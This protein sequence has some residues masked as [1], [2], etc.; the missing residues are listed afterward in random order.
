[1]FSETKP[2]SELTVEELAAALKA[3]HR[4][5][6]REGDEWR[7]LAQHVLGLMKLAREERLSASTEHSIRMR[8]WLGHGHVGQYGDDGEMQCGACLP[9]G[10]YDYKRAS[11]EELL[12]TVDAVSLVAL[13]ASFQEKQP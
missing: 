10:T 6:I 1:M 11:L 9:F 3:G 4:A 7:P 8:L 13:R 12:K 5:I 2:L